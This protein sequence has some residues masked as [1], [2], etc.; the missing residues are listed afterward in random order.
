MPKAPAINGIRAAFLKRFLPLLLA[1]DNRPNSKGQAANDERHDFYDRVTRALVLCFGQSDPLHNDTPG[2]LFDV[3]YDEIPA[4]NAMPPLTEEEAEKRDA[5]IADLTNTVHTWYKNRRTEANSAKGVAKLTNRQVE[6]VVAAHARVPQAPKELDIYQ[7]Y[8]KDQ[9]IDAFNTSW[10]DRLD[11][12]RDDAKALLRMRK[13]KSGQERVFASGR[14]LE[15]DES[16]KADVRAKCKEVHDDELK[17]YRALWGCPH[18]ALPNSRMWAIPEAGAFFASLLH[19]AASRFGVALAL[20]IAGPTDSGEPEANS[21]YAAGHSVDGAP[22]LAIFADASFKTGRIR[23]KQYARDFLTGEVPVPDTA[24]PEDGSAAEEGA[25]KDGVGAHVKVAVLKQGGKRVGEDEDGDGDEDEDEEEEEEEEAVVDDVDDG[26]G[27][28]EHVTRA[29]K[30]P[31][32]GPAQISHAQ[33]EDHLEPPEQPTTVR[34]RRRPV[35]SAGRNDGENTR[36]RTYEPRTGT[37]STTPR[38]PHS[39]LL[40]AGTH[41]GRMAEN[42]GAELGRGPGSRVERTPFKRRPRAPSRARTPSEGGVG[43]VDLDFDFGL[44]PDF[45][46]DTNFVRGVAEEDQDEYDDAPASMRGL[47][48]SFSSAYEAGGS[49]LDTAFA[50]LLSDDDEATWAPSHYAASRRRAASA[51]SGSPETTSSAYAVERLL[52]ERKQVTRTQSAEEVGA[53]AED[54]SL[55]AD[56][57]LSGVFSDRRQ[58]K[59]VAKSTRVDR[60]G[61]IS[62][63]RAGAS[64]KKEAGIA[65]ATP[66][67]DQEDAATSNGSQGRQAGT[68]GKA[69]RSKKSGESTSI[70]GKVTAL[71]RARESDRAPETGGGRRRHR[72]MQVRSPSPA[73]EDVEMDT[74][75]APAAGASEGAQAEADVSA[76]DI[77]MQGWL[78]DHLTTPPKDVKGAWKTYVSAPAG[79]MSK[80]HKVVE[81]ITA[82]PSA[83][84]VVYADLVDSMEDLLKC[85]DSWDGEGGGHLDKARRPRPVTSMIKGRGRLLSEKDVGGEWGKSVRDWWLSLQPP[86]RGT[87]VSIAELAEP[88]ED[89]E[90]G[91]LKEACGYKGPFLLVWCMMHWVKF[92]G[93]LSEWQDVAEDM[94]RVYRVLQDKRVSASTVGSRKRRAVDD[95]D[96][97]GRQTKSAKRSNNPRAGR[98]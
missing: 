33:E 59:T 90:W 52:P 25:D 53:A 31:K 95:G 96:G 30:T 9:Y 50:N 66:N 4:A 60:I 38:R 64:R 63:M 35:T 85:D 27:A 13:R 72:P 34:D 2:D 69:K 57:M 41:S 77:L 7:K 45:D 92:D 10:A 93:D 82:L 86:D 73:D 3:T 89:M 6:R 18:D 97:D 29:S 58:K 8:F 21:I 28:G 42:D 51:R 65:S 68:G 84:R 39:P 48:P 44:D 49:D 81:V 74:V 98:R 17:S 40:R 11:S 14:W 62:R 88:T 55:L 15:E 5:V 16:V 87:D 37:Q 76:D 23:L 61:G 75:V 67:H 19:W 79:A 12:V 80:R 46:I 47:S 26:K 22:E 91:C 36:S 54:E 78:R 70:A 71:M 83:A 1:I 20:T 56:S 43:D 32:A 94:T 24:E